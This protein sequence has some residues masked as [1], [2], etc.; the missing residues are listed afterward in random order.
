MIVTC[1]KFIQTHRTIVCTTITKKWTININYGLQ[2]IL[3]CQYR[4]LIV[5][6]ALPPDGFVEDRGGYVCVGQGIYGKSLDIHF[7]LKYFFRKQ[8]N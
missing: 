3:L 8:C 2:V 5:I 7:Y 6:D 4:L 1:H